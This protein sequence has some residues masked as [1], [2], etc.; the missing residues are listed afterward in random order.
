[1]LRKPALADFSRGM[2]SLWVLNL[3]ARKKNPQTEVCAT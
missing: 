1:V 3:G 2:F